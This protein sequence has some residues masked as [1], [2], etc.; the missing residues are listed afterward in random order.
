MLD[1]KNHL[2]SKGNMKRQMGK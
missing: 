1:K 2:I